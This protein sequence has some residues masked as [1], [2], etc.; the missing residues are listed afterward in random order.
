MAATAAQQRLAYSSAPLGGSRRPARAVRL[1]VAAVAAPPMMSGP[2]QASPP[3][4]RNGGFGTEERVLDI[5]TM[6]RD[7]D[8]LNGRSNLLQ[9]DSEDDEE[10][11]PAAPVAMWDGGELDR[12]SLASAAPWG[13]VAADYASDYS[14]AVGGLTPEEQK[15]LDDLDGE[16]PLTQVQAL[17]SG[18][19]TVSPPAGPSPLVP[20][21]DSPAPPS[22]YSSDGGFQEMQAHELAERLATGQVALLLDVRSPEE[23]ARG[24]VTGATNVPLDALSAAVRE[25]GLDAYRAK[26]VAVVCASGMRSSQATV[27]PVGGAEGRGA[28]GAGGTWRC[29]VSSTGARAAPPLLVA[30][31]YAEACICACAGCLLP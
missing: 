29:W 18:A 13:D 3:A 19:V 10:S 7:F 8:P 26:P 17:L 30:P 14:P 16:Q 27:R 23:F 5:S 31:L 6:L 11:G 21:D 22:A 25:G 20:A 9:W 2:R 28:K 24:H 1:Q 4:Q 15:T 12:Y